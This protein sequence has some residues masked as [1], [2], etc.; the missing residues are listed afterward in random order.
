MRIRPVLVVLAVVAAACADSGGGDTAPGST[1]EL[2]VV[3]STATAGPTSSST[4]APATSQPTA[5][6]TGPDTTPGTT[7]A[8]EPISPSPVTLGPPDAALLPA[9]PPDRIDWPAVGRGWLLIDHPFGY[10][11]PFVEPITMNRRGLYLVTPGSV[12][13]G[14]SALPSDGSR[15]AAVS[16]DGR[17]VLLELFDPVCSDGCECPGGP[18][19]TVATDEQ[20][21]DRDRQQQAFGYVLLDLPTTTLRPIIDPVAVPV[22]NPGVFH[23]AVDFT[24]DG[25]GIFVSETWFTEDQARAT[26]VRLSRV[27]LT[28]AAWTTVLDETVEADEET[29]DRQYGAGH[30]PRSS[31]WI[32][33][34]E[35]DGGWIVTG[36]P[37]GMWV[38]QPDGAS[39]RELVAPDGSCAVERVWDRDHVLARCLPADD[40]PTSGLWLLALDGSA[41]E[42]LAVQAGDDGEL[43]CWLSYQGAERI[44]DVLAVQ[45]E[46]D[47]CSDQVIFISAD[48]EITDWDPVV[49]NACGETLVGTRHD[50]WMIEA[51]PESDPWPVVFEVT[52]EG[53]TRIELPSGQIIPISGTVP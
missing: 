36:T 38:R 22:C 33:V 40:C 46:G 12:T 4:S 28:T 51:R 8:L 47:G 13:Y 20:R 34:V 2:S 32:S 5:P 14:A 15:I 35:L 41:A 19:V 11:G 18:P 6:S 9:L 26:R 39:V 3:T 50:A 31:W 21:D 37:S 42:P 25:R 29:E 48:G 49:D 45:V 43:R 44:G 23:R 52:G 27:D 16:D 30:A 10:G 1:P 24:S 7:S 17:Q 53:S